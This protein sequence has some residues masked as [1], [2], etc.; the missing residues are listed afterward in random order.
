VVVEAVVVITVAAAMAAVGAAGPA[1]AGLVA[2][3]GEDVINP[4]SAIYF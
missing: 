4:F 2:V 3:A 1:A